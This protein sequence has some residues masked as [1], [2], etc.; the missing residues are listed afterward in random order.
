MGSL[1]VGDDVECD[2]ESLGSRVLNSTQ[3]WFVVWCDFASRPL[4]TLQLSPVI[5][6]GM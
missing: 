3:E 6:M 4:H 1:T 2:L 5:P